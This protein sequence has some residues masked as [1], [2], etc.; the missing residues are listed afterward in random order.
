MATEIQV[1]YIPMLSKAD[2]R[3]IHDLG[4]EVNIPENVEPRIMASG[5]KP[6]DYIVIF[7]IYFSLKVVDELTNRMAKKLAANF[8]KVV[9]RLWTKLKGTKPYIL[10]SRGPIYFLP[11]AIV[12]FKISDDEDSKL[13]LTN[14]LSDKQIEFAAKAFLKLVKLQFKNRKK[15]SELKGRLKK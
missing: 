8:Y 5:L 10:E 1:V 13:E 11:K 2:F 6:E 12:S 7:T 15:E 9:R 14:E 4:Y 3:D